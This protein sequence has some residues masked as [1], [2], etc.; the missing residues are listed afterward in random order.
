MA[1]K[2]TA[3][4]QRRGYGREA[5]PKNQ[6]MIQTEVCQNGPYWVVVKGEKEGDRRMEQEW[7]EVTI[8]AMGIR[9]RMYTRATNTS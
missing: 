2:P 7:G 3:S 4:E 8:K 9:R 5:N 6:T 1:A